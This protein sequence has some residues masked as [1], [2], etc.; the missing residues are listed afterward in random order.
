MLVKFWTGV[1]GELEG[2]LDFLKSGNG[3]QMIVPLLFF[4]SA[5]L[6]LW[7]IFMFKTRIRQVNVNRLNIVINFLLLGIMVF[8]LLNLPGEND[9]SEKG[10]GPFLPIISI[11]FL[12]LANK[13][14]LKDERLVKSVD[15]LR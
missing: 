7:T 11:V 8:V 14:I 13:A 12:S 1:N 10:I 15:R 6:S 9:F 5:V 4:L 3:T 2:L